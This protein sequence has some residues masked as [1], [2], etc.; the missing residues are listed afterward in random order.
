V[1][2]AHADHRKLAEN[3][4][5]ARA[6]HPRQAPRVTRSGF[7]DVKVTPDEHS[8]RPH[9]PEHGSR[10]AQ[11]LNRPGD[12]DERDRLLD[13]LPLRPP[14]VDAQTVE[15]GVARRRCGSPRGPVGVDARSPKPWK[16]E[17][18]GLALRAFQLRRNS[19]LAGPSHLSQPRSEP[20][21]AMCTLASRRCQRAHCAGVR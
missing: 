4:E 14:P 7:T 1:S 10:S 2:N 20:V 16:P 17:A 6:T 9:V 11:A 18:L 13:R 8:F 5:E 19:R 12:L 21:G 15:D 3:G